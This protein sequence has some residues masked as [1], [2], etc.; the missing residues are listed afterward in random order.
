MIFSRVLEWFGRFWS[1]VPTIKQPLKIGAPFHVRRFPNTLTLWLEAL[2]S[3]N[4]DESQFSTIPPLPP[5]VVT[6]TTQTQTSWTK[7]R[8]TSLDSCMTNSS[9]KSLPLYCP[10]YY[11]YNA[12]SEIPAVV[13]LIPTNNLDDSTWV[14]ARAP[15]GNPGN[16]LRPYLNHLL[17]INQSIHVRI[18]GYDLPQEND[19]VFFVE[20]CDTCKTHRLVIKKEWVDMG[21]DYHSGTGRAMEYVEEEGEVN[22]EDV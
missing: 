11:R 9:H 1:P 8:T 20:N 21:E 5:I 7:D 17:F 16:L 15:C 13:C 6:V 19:L 22:N 18:V 4:L 14:A 10:P 3:G 2:T 12:P